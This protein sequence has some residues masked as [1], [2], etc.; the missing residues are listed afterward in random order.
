MVSLDPLGV[1]IKTDTSQVIC[2]P[3]SMETPKSPPRQGILHI[4]SNTVRH[5]QSSAGEFPVRVTECFG[6][7]S[8]RQLLLGT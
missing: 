7:L 3:V 6:V 1:R 2:I 5:A 8:D 4:Q